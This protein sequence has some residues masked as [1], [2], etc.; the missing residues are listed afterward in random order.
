MV[1]QLIKHKKLKQEN[2]NEKNKTKQKNHKIK[3]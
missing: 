2:Q 3:H 1:Q